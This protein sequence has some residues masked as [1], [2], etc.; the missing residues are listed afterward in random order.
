MSVSSLSPN[1]LNALAY[2]SYRLSAPHTCPSRPLP[3]L[4]SSHYYSFLLGELKGPGGDAGEARLQNVTACFISLCIHFRLARLARAADPQHYRRPSDTMHKVYGLQTGCGGGVWKL[5]VLQA[6]TEWKVG[7]GAY[8]DELEIVSCVSDILTHR[9]FT[10]AHLL[11]LLTRTFHLGSPRLLPV[12]HL[13]PC[14][15]RTVVRHS[16]LIRLGPLC[17]PGA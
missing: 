15:L 6:A 1:M 16:T 11:A 7:Q 14:H 2:L 13:Y 17:G 12:S 9:F 10:K 8:N 5:E 3:V 4:N